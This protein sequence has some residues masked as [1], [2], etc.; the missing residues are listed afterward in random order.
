MMN[1]V[2]KLNKDMLVYFVN[3]M[4]NYHCPFAVETYKSFVATENT[5]GWWCAFHNMCKAFDLKEVEDNVL[6]MTDPIEVS[7]FCHVITIT[8]VKNDIIEL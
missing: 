4:K 1:I 8:L 5:F 6:Q 3:E 2:E 7:T